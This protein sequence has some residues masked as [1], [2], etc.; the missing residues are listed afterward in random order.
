MRFFLSI[1]LSIPI[2][3]AFST[4][5][6]LTRRV[7]RWRDGDMRIRWATAGLLRAESKFRRLRGFREIPQLIHA[8]EAEVSGKDQDQAMVA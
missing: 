6:D 4:T 3:S 1:I 2:E 5:A 8:L 7:K